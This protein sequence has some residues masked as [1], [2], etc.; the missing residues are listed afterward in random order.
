MLVSANELYIKPFV[1]VFPTLVG[2]FRGDVS[3]KPSNTQNYRGFS[4]HQWGFKQVRSDVPVFLLVCKNHDK[5][6]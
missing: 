2:M 3:K 6:I 1:S 5:I 4:P